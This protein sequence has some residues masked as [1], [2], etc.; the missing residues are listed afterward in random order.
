LFDFWL[1]HF[2]YALSFAG[3]HQCYTEKYIMQLPEMS[4]YAKV[5]VNKM[6][7]DFRPYTFGCTFGLVKDV[8]KQ[9]G[10]KYRELE[11]CVEF[12]APKSRLQFFV[13]KLHF[14]RI[15]YSTKPL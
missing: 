11:N 3:L 6:L 8:C 9:Y 2:T 12:T 15:S 4:I 10:V 5:S 13:E 14:S 7:S 1:L